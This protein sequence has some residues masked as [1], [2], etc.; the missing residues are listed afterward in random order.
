MKKRHR[1]LCITFIYMSVPAWQRATIASN[2]PKDDLNQ[3]ANLHRSIKT[4]NFVFRTL[5][6]LNFIFFKFS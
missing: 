5:K 2:D 4:S 3:I 1:I 6:M